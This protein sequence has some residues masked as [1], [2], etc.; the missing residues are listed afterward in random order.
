[1]V[2]SILVLHKDLALEVTLIILI[3]EGQVLQIILIIMNVEENIEIEL[4]PIGEE[5]LL[6]GE[7]IHT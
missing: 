2:I 1:V 7:I 4:M 3:M 6:L 5:E